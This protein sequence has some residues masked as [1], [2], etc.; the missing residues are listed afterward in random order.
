M[1]VSALAEHLH[2]IFIRIANQYMAMYLYD[3]HHEGHWM[4][5]ENETIEY[6]NIQQMDII[7]LKEKHV[8]KISFVDGGEN[9]SLSCSAETK[10]SEL[11]K[12]IICSI[13]SIV[14][15]PTAVGICCVK[16]NNQLYKVEDRLWLPNDSLFGAHHLQAGDEIHLS[17]SENPNALAIARLLIT[18]DPHSSS[19]SVSFFPSSL[20]DCTLI[21]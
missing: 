19:V 17:H 3:E 13:S 20:I 8:Y 14:D 16:K 5:K 21:I 15:D 11:I 1:K 6:Y 9:S 7:E 12:M 10:I 18:S 4:D 2:S